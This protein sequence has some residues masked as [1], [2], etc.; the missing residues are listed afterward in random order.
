MTDAAA[1]AIR[2]RV[3]AQEL[4]DQG[5]RGQG[6]GV[7]ILDSGF[8]PRN[9]FDPR[10]I[11][12]RDFTGEGRPRHS[13][14]WHGSTVAT[15]LSVLAPETR[16]GNFR[17]IPAEA[18]MRREDVIAALDAVVAAFPTYR[19]A[20]LSLS[21]APEG[22]PDACPL[23]Q[24]VE[25]A[26]R[27]GVLVV[28]AA[29]NEGPAPDT[30]TCPAR[31]HWALTV[32]ATLPETVNDYWRD[33]RWAR[34]WAQH[35]TGRFGR[36]YGTSY[37]AGYMSGQ[38]AMLFSA[39]PGVSAD[40]LRFALLEAA[41]VAETEGRATASTAQAHAQLARLQGLV[42]IGAIVTKSNALFPMVEKF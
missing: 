5:Y 18:P 19:I 24:A 9:G 1:P 36:S 4:Y 33:H 40:T 16:L 35:V 42:R 39:F 8:L 28:V 13:S 30:L 3:E 41:R 26:Y 7:A 21:F 17:V 15:C 31:A 23:C 20:N 32:T 27:A 12:E 11:E 34:I 37:S 14:N 38:A 6:V 22:C 29:G 10:V 25:R 2:A